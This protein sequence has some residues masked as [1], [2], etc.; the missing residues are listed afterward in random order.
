VI[1]I[2]E[3][4]IIMDSK[5]LIQIEDQYSAHNYHPLDVVIERGEGVWVYD[6]EGERYLDCL[7]SYSALNHGHLHPRLVKVMMEQLGKVSLTS[8]AFR[9]DQFPLLCKELCKLTGY[10]NFLP[11]NTGAEAVETALKAARKWACEKKGILEDNVEI[12]ACENNFHGRTITIISFSSEPSY[13]NGFGPFTPG[14]KI[15]PYADAGALEA[16]ISPNT[17]AFLFEPIQ[18]EAGVIVPPVG[19]LKEVHEICKK[20]NVLMLADEIQTG[21][22]RTGKW[23]ACDHEGV[24]PDILIVGKALGGGLYP[25]SGVLASKEILDVFTYGIHGST[26]GGNPLGAAVAREGLRVLEEEKLVERSASLG[27]YF[28]G[29][30]RKRLGSTANPHVEQ[31]RGKGLFVGVVLKREAGGARR[32]C[33][34]LKAEHVLCKETHDNIIRF[35]PPLI[36]DQETIDWAVKRIVKVLNMP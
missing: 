18:G 33:E 20:H 13:R 26:F 7:S 1:V 25:V 8:R 15:I 30:L 9:N 36:I 4:I 27:D 11:M 14:F 12:I 35:A 23:F 32:F 28:M 19:Y 6:I 5:E 24:H 22:G 10:E 3:K 16:A 31:I 2:P 34:M 29:E 17:A 21:L